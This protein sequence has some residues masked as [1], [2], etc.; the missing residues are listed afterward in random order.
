M[1]LH[2]NVDKDVKMYDQ[3]RKFKIKILLWNISEAID[4]GKKHYLVTLIKG[5]VRYVCLKVCKNWI[6]TYSVTATMSL[7]AS[8]IPFAVIKV[9]L[10]NSQTFRK[11]SFFFSSNRDIQN[12]NEQP[13]MTSDVQGGFR[14]QVIW[15]E[16]QRSKP[17]PQRWMTGWMLRLCLVVGQRERGCPPPRSRRLA[18]GIIAAVK[19]QVL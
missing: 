16:H 17:L 15:C 12:F 7:S 14:G 9:I 11:F 5:L 1:K 18:E 10:C 4:N 3:V 6:G 13:W 2:F 8:L 19:L